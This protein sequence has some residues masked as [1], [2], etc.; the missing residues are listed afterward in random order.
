[1]ILLY[2][3][4]TENTKYEK[5]YVRG[6]TNVNIK[7]IRFWLCQWKR[8]TDFMLQKNYFVICKKIWCQSKEPPPPFSKQFPFSPTPPFLEKIYHPHPYCHTWGTQTPLL[9]KRKYVSFIPWLLFL[10]NNMGFGIVSLLWEQLFDHFQCD[11]LLSDEQLF[12]RGN[13]KKR[14]IR[15]VHPLCFTKCISCKMARDER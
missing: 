7:Y 14:E 2:A 3:N 9:Y 11:N 12:K 1:M 15:L 13:I 5:L 4:Y 6:L 10:P 8:D